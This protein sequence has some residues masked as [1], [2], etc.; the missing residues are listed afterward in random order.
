MN[1]TAD[2]DPLA[3]LNPEQRAA[4]NHDGGPLCVLA[5]AGSGKTRVIERRVRVLLNRGTPPERILLLT[6]TK[7]AATE[8]RERLEQATPQA[9]HITATTYHGF[10]FTLLR[11]IYPELGLERAPTVI[12][13]DDAKRLLNKLAKERN[14]RTKPIPGKVLLAI[15]SATINRSLT[16][17]DAT[18]ADYP[19]YLDRLDEISDIREQYRRRKREQHL[20]DFDDLLIALHRALKDP[21]IAP[22][23]TSRYDH[24]LIDEYQDTNRLQGAITWLLAPH[25]EVTIVADQDQ[26]IYA[27]RGAHYGNLKHVLEQKDMTVETLYTNYRSNQAILDLANTV[28]AQMPSKE[29]K[30]LKSTTRPGGLPPVALPF[31]NV[32]EEAAYVTRHIR[33]LLDTGSNPNE[34]AVLYRSSYL[35]IPLQ[36]A[37]LRD[38]IPFR[39]FGGSSLTST[40]HIRDL[41]AFLRMI[42][43]PED[44]LAV[45]RVL[46]LHPGIGPATAD[47]I[48]ELLT[49]NAAEELDEIA[50]TA[51]ANQRESLHAVANLILKV[52]SGATEDAVSTLIAYYQPIMERLYDDPEQR[53]RD[54]NAFQEIASQYQDLSLLV[55]DLMLDASA[56]D[57]TTVDAVTLSTVHA[58]K[59]LEWDNVVVIGANDS[60]LPHYKVVNEGGPEGIDEERR[61]AYVAITRARETLLITY[62]TA[63]APGQENEQEISR[64]LEHLAP[65]KANARKA[66]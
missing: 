44:R 31:N 34:I 12:D 33:K 55:S 24:V 5:G 19:S 10:A 4:A 28:L 62:P 61:L 18:G 41:L 35:N 32:S 17:E 42:L 38:G 64:F 63:P 13:Q 9:A 56:E 7:R 43:N 60:S 48:S 1:T 26:A 36:A 45:S 46:T 16:L 29:K 20:V 22:T 15:H 49:F 25:R 40:A 58:S 8:M 14:T 50:A 53:M 3:G 54:L 47:K 59:G 65:A 6:F 51:R 23:I 37:L 11:E 30:V 66:A 2:R 52:W 57:G 21:E 39:T 27:F